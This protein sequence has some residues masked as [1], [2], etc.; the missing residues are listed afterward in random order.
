[1]LTAHLPSLFLLLSTIIG[2]SS[3][4]TSEPYDLVNGLNEAD[5]LSDSEAEATVSSAYS[6][7]PRSG[8]VPVGFQGFYDEDDSIFQ[9]QNKNLSPDGTANRVMGQTSRSSFEGKTKT[10]S[11]IED[12]SNEA[13]SHHNLAQYHDG[14]PAETARSYGI[15]SEETSSSN[16]PTYLP[17][18][19]NHEAH[20]YSGD[21]FEKEN[22]L[23]DAASKNIDY[24]RGYG[25]GY[26]SSEEAHREVSPMNYDSDEYHSRR[27]IGYQLTLAEKCLPRNQKPPSDLLWI[28]VLAFV[29]KMWSWYYY[30]H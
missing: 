13:S 4:G 21:E 15:G 7:L 20:S 2:Q 18:Y 9:R 14:R 5:N 29:L 28:L 10:Q 12:M 22:E 24:A 6:P 8:K 16:G 17:R 25:K 30:S 1:M 19:Y 26:D 3:A 27:F 23:K 11:D